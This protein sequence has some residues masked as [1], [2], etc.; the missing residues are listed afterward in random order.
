MIATHTSLV[1]ALLLL[2]GAAFGQ[3]MY[4]TDELVITLRTG[5]S[6]ENSIIEN[7]SSG[8]RVEV[9]ESNEAA[10]Y[11]RVRVAASGE[12]GWVLTR[13]LTA[14][15]TAALALSDTSRDLSAAR[16]RIVELEE[17][18]A[19]LTERLNDSDSRLAATET[20]AASLSDELSEVRAASANAI[21]LRDQNESLRRRNN[22]M[23]QQ[24]DELTASNRELAS[25]N[26]Q[27]WFVVG[28]LV[29][30]A[31]IVVGL[32]APSLRRKRRSSW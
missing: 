20:S 25:R 19:A 13:F 31:G 8:D 24:I 22:T 27:N 18:V 12:E 15:Q 32:I 6:T 16:T 28:A 21:A 1:L 4:V 14:E 29:L 17:Q 11:S 9:V 2:C 30:V 7:L 26:N 23:S 10:G 3:T 5:P